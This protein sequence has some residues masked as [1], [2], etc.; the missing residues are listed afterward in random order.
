MKSRKSYVALVAL[1]FIFF[2]IFKF[3]HVRE[4]ENHLRLSLD[5]AIDTLDTGRSYSDD[6]LLVIAQVAEPLYQYH[7]L[8]RPYEIEP[9]TAEK[10]PE[11]SSDGLRVTVKIK[12]G[13]FYHRHP[14]LKEKRVLKSADFKMAL[15]RIALK[16]FKSP[17]R[18]IFSDLIVGFEDFDQKVNGDWQNLEKIEISGIKT[19]SDTEIVFEL[20]RP[21]PLFAHYLAQSFLSPVPAEIVFFMKNDL[22]KTIVG[23]GP[24]EMTN[25]SSSRY[26]LKRNLLF[27]QEF[28]PASGDRYAN[29]QNLLDS[30]RELL[31]FIDRI[32]FNV[33]LKENDLWQKFLED[34]IDLMVVPKT[35][36]S[37]IFNTNGEPNEDLTRKKIE[38][39]HF[40]I[41]ANRWLSFNM[42]RGLAA[43]H[44]KLRQAIAYGLNYEKYIADL[45]QNTNL[46]SNSILVPGI[47]GYSPHSE[48]VFQF[49]PEKAR[50]LVSE[51]EKELGEI[52]LK[53]STRGNQSIHLKEAEFFK[54][55][56]A[57][58]GL[59]LEVE[60]LTFTE[61]LQKGRAGELEL[62]TDNWLFD[63]P[64]AE[65]IFQ[66][67]LS[68]NSPGI[69][70]SGFHH[71]Q[72]DKLFHEL[73][74]IRSPEKRA[75]S[76]AQMENL[77]WEALPWI[78]LM[79]ESSFVL[80][81]PE[82]KN[83]RKSSIIRNYI[84]Y[85]KISPED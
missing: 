84:K 81:H 31:P 12:P 40:P 67:L 9:L 76:L 71:P 35:L 32:T 58:I 80:Q 63:F 15:K 43:K 62:F 24:Y 75:Q 20:N 22:S 28:Y 64:E 83:Y 3:F 77:V 70:K 61:F 11:I 6:S 37:R 30:S 57:L 33:G 25:V 51:L 14:A 29:I 60:V 72:F 42:K 59:D 73:S 16:N 74:S 5:Q 68:T 53:Y 26:E 45:S 54:T 21:E 10:L 48:L 38:I 41:L 44:L 82:I 19:P 7:Y 55:N 17:A 49:D 56:L 50:G 1:V 79:Y 8:K 65:N 36:I 39:K 52:K 23:T 46:R 47:P 13:L 78:P 4:R 2:L 85:L 69:N 34:E 27:R 66:L 18:S